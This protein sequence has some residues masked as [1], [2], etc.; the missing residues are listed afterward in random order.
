MT[1]SAARFRL[2]NVAESTE[3]ARLTL[4]ETISP[5]LK[6]QNTSCIILSAL[7]PGFNNVMSPLSSERAS[8]V[9]SYQTSSIFNYV[10]YKSSKLMFPIS[11]AREDI[12]AIF[13]PSSP[14]KPRAKVSVGRY[15]TWHIYLHVR[16]S[17][18]I[19]L[20]KNRRKY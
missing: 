9:T 17:K 1:H 20:T 10:F 2:E 6:K 18:Q 13:K 15:Q 5:G 8:P 16:R 3:L 12:P 19:K 7:D 14:L 4:K 11:G